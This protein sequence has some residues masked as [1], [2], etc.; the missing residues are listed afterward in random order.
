MLVAVEVLCDYYTCKTY[1]NVA[2]IVQEKRSN[3]F[4]LA[5]WRYNEAM[6]SAF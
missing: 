2:E 1:Q 4:F 3:L 5:M 6:A